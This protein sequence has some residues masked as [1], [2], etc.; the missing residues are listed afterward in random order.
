MANAAVNDWITLPEMKDID[1]SKI[2]SVTFNKLVA[3]ED[4]DG[5]VIF[6]GGNFVPV[7][8][9]VNGRQAF[10]KPS[11]QFIPNTTYEMRIFIGD[12]RYKMNFESIGSTESGGLIY[13]GKKDVRSYFAN[14]QLIKGINHYIVNLKEGYP[15]NIYVT[16]D[17]EQ[18]YGKGFAYEE[19]LSMIKSIEAK[20]KAKP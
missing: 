19:M 2:F 4:I 13:E 18:R 9:T 16:N 12:R 7:E 3:I 10:V 17:Y 14:D 15:I 6:Q 11:H 1:S 8:I 20:R 5:I